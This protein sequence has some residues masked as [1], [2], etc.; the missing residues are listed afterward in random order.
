MAHGVETQ[1][2][3][4][5]LVIRRTPPA[6][7]ALF[8]LVTLPADQQMA[9]SVEIVHRKAARYDKTHPV[10]ADALAV[11][12][13]DLWAHTAFRRSPQVAARKK[14]HSEPIERLTDALCYVG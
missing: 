13:K 12:R 6:L 9:R 2:Q 4:S 10:L 7:L 8:S 14:S 1:R 11:V 5:E 3:W